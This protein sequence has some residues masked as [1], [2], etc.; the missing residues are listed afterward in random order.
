[1]KSFAHSR[2]LLLVLTLVVC[3][4]GSYFIRRASGAV[5]TQRETRLTG[6]QFDNFVFYW[7]MY[8]DIKLTRD[9]R[10]ELKRDVFQYWT[11]NNTVEIR[12]TLQQAE[13][14][15]TNRELPQ[16]VLADM[17]T[18][19]QAQHLAGLRSEPNDPMS[20][21][22]LKIY[23]RVHGFGGGDDGDNSPAASAVLAQGNPPLTQAMAD[24]FLSIYSFIFDLN[25]N[26]AQ[27]G[28]LQSL[29]VEAWKK[30]D[31]D[32][33]EHVAGDLKAVGDKSKDDLVA[34][35]G[36]DYQNTFVEGFR[37]GGMQTPLFKAFVE[38]FDEAHPD[39]R[40]AT[41]AKGF[42]DLVGTWEWSDALLQERNPYNG[43]LQGI[44][45]VDAG[46]LEISPDGQ[47]KLIHTHR[48]CAG[49]C[50]NEQ[51]KSEQGTVS[52]EGGELVFQIKSGTEMARDGCNA[53]LNQ[54]AAIKPHRESYNWSIRLNPNHD[55][56]PTL[57][58]NTGPHEAT[59]YIKQQ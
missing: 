37:R 17:R 8:L 7:E 12:N 44:G 13:S 45:Y 20:V 19:Y 9:E 6:E 54:Q 14:G 25:L 18:A 41:R 55:N 22:L 24:K 21:L 33:I 31:R 2:V 49:A 35:L 56:A 40:E 43:N 39:R 47:F 29:L 1:M 34:T 27:R 4:Y 52:V 23:N 26:A 42:A 58:W 15:A 28:R 57:C 16:S 50:C 5:A 46:T 59:C 3:V 48:H 10:E 36:A 51:G 53:R 30:N 32:V 38:L 11:T